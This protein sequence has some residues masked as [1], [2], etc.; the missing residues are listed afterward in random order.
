MNNIKAFPVITKTR[1]WKNNRGELVTDTEYC[2]GGMTLLDYFAGLTLNGAV[3]NREVRLSMHA[4]YCEMDKRKKPKSFEVFMVKE[5]YKIAEIMLK[6]R[7]NYE[8]PK[9]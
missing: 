8:I 7:E 6:E 9:K 5:C 2:E 1:Q 4:E 3:S